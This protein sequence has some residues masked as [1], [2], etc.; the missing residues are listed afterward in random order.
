MQRL[1]FDPTL[2]SVPD[3]MTEAYATIWNAL[4]DFRHFSEEDAVAD[5]NQ[6]WRVNNENQR[7]HWDKQ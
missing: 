4:S 2:E 6:A 7:Q 1:A 3:H 5:L